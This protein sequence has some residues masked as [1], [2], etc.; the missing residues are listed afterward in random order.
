MEDL[1]P[2]PPWAC[3][4]WC[5]LWWH[6][7]IAGC[8]LPVLEGV[9]P[10]AVLAHET[11]WTLVDWNG[12]NNK[13]VSSTQDSNHC[14]YCGGEHL[15]EKERDHV[16]FLRCS[17]IKCNTPDCPII[18][19]MNMR[20]F[21]GRSQSL[22]EMG[23]VESPRMNFDVSCSLIYHHPHIFFSYSLRTHVLGM[24]LYLWGRVFN[25]VKNRLSFT[26]LIR[27]PSLLQNQRLLK[28]EVILSFLVQSSC[29]V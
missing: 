25:F 10:C 26:G 23:P 24:V 28:W 17:E 19:V 6:V 21:W 13:G 5:P 27:K 3:T 16:G 7:G 1:I 8:T 20:K 2:C 11:F 14:K 9:A 4:L 29:W 22:L 18:D 12:W 15:K